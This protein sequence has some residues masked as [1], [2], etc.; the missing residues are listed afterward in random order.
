[1]NHSIATTCHTHIQGFLRDDVKDMS[2]TITA[3]MNHYMV[4]AGRTCAA[5]ILLCQAST[6]AS[7]K[8]VL[9]FV[10]TRKIGSSR[11][12]VLHAQLQFMQLL[13]INESA[14]LHAC[15]ENGCEY[16]RHKNKKHGKHSKR[17]CPL[18]SHATIFSML[19]L[20]QKC[21]R[22]NDVRNLQK[23]FLRVRFQAEVANMC[24]HRHDQLMRCDAG[25]NRM[26]Y[27]TNVTEES[28]CRL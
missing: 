23:L 10:V 3:G 17:S 18:C 14:P 16:E 6:H 15:Y 12:H 26:D 19:C 2:S 8:G 25:I 1:V 21:C 4:N 5:N 27:A 7:T 9:G 20:P 28:N 11:G 22:D 13:A 24:H